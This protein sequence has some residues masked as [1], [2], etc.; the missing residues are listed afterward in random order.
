MSAITTNLNRLKSVK[1]NLKEAL[2]LMG[3]DMSLYT[4]EDYPDLI[5]SIKKYLLSAEDGEQIALVL[6][7][8]NY[9]GYCASAERMTYMEGQDNKL[10]GIVFST[11]NVQSAGVDP[12]ELTDLTCLALLRAK[13]FYLKDNPNITKVSIPEGITSMFRF[14]NDMTKLTSVEIANDLSKCENMQSAFSGCTSLNDVKFKTELSSATNISYLF[15]GCTALT[16]VQFPD[17]PS[18]TNASYLFNGCS[19]LASLTMPSMP[20]AT[21]LS[22]FLNGCTTLANVKLADLT[23]AVYMQYFFSGCKALKT[24]DLPDALPNV[25]NVTGMLSNCTAL[26]TFLKFPD[27]PKVS[28]LNAFLSGC[29]ALTEVFFPEAMDK[30][31]N[32]AWA[33]QGTKVSEVV[34]PKSM[35]SCT[36]MYGMFKNCTSLKTLEMP[37][38]M[39]ELINADTFCYNATSLR[40]VVM[41]KSMPK[42]QVMGNVTS[43]GAGYGMFQGCKALRS[44]VLPDEMPAV[45]NMASTFDGCSSLAS[46]TMPTTMGAVTNMYQTFYN[47]SSLASL[48]M[49]TTM[50]AVTTMQSTFEGCSSLA[51][52][53]MP[54][55]M[56]A[57]TN[58]QSTFYG[59]GSLASL[60]MPAMPNVTE[61]KNAFSS[62]VKLAEFTDTGATAKGYG[63]NTLYLPKIQKLWQPCDG[64]MDTIKIVAPNGTLTLF[65]FGNT[66]VR[67]IDLSECD[68]SNVTTWLDSYAVS[69]NV[70]V[71]GKF[72]VKKI[73]SYYSSTLGYAFGDMR[74]G[75]LKDLGVADTAINLSQVPWGVSDDN[76]DTADAKDSLIWSLFGDDTYSGIYDRSGGTSLTLQLSAETKAL[77]TEDQLN[78]LALRGYTIA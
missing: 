59:C 47:C 49:P 27:M 1:K 16:G 64:A 4:F 44:L 41:P 15:N 28:S 56:G 75:Y 34:L 61:M 53:T 36:T 52:L 19:K 9:L 33:L 5:K 13:D 69:G 29:T 37:D 46:L 67:T 11:A 66:N 8:L 57:V 22:Y 2:A 50:G 17:L 26:T 38:E 48:T 71:K 30:V 32:M 3:Y 20:K 65:T 58:M 74:V 7:V 31:T 45:T 40:S 55:T 77:L 10:S 35:K 14:A 78:E 62:C 73:A 12:T 24:I 54:T 25:E 70:V 43:W 39:P 6:K 21:D 63:T 23:S 42:L 51:S 76:D 60:T 18:V 72:S 68:T